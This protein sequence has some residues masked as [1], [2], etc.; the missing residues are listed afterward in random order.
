MHLRHFCQDTVY[1]MIKQF[2]DIS[3]NKFRN[4]LL[5]VRSVCSKPIFESL[6]KTSSGQQVPT[7]RLNE[8]FQSSTYIHS[9]KR[10]A[11][12]TF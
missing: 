6:K 10:N 11:E 12:R 4:F 5:S 9:Q 1:S 8:P 2:A 7:E 3:E